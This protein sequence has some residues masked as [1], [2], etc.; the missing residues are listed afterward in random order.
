MGRTRQKNR[1]DPELDAERKQSVQYVK[2]QIVRDPFKR[3][4]QEQRIAERRNSIASIYDAMLDRY[5]PTRKDNETN[6]KYSEKAVEIVLHNTRA[7]LPLAEI[8]ERY[9]EA[10][11]PDT[12]RKWMADRPEVKEAYKQ[13]IRE[14]TESLRVQLMEMGLSE[15]GLYLDETGD[16]KVFNVG[17]AFR[18]TLVKGIINDEIKRRHPQRYGRRAIEDAE[19]D[20]DDN[21]K[22]IIGLDPTANTKPRK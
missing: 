5:S 7:G 6:I 19:P 22:Q 4:R 14:S 10:P 9:G 3:Q 16:R 17:E 11:H 13:A 1:S 21:V 2:A 15:E 12:F 20:K 8:Y 18:R